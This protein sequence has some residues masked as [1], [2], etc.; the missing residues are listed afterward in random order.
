MCMHALNARVCYVPTFPRPHSAPKSYPVSPMAGFFGQH[1][2]IFL[3]VPN[4]IGKLRAQA[5]T[6]CAAFHANAKP[7]L[8]GQATLEWHVRSTHFRWRS[9][10]RCIAP[11]RTSLGVCIFPSRVTLLLLLLTRRNLQVCM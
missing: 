2:R 4:L 11:L 7:H 6:V 10:S 3:Y 1:R 9:P 8:R 5:I